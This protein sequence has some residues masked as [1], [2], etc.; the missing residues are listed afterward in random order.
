M[1]RRSHVSKPAGLSAL[2]PPPCL[3]QLQAGKCFY[4]DNVSSVQVIMQT[5]SAESMQST[6][7]ADETLNCGRYGMYHANDCNINLTYGQQERTV[8]PAVSS[9]IC[10]DVHVDSISLHIKIKTTA[11]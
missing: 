8:A 7:V 9:D 5:S 2:P 1:W 11:S 4:H 6:R 10:S 3:D